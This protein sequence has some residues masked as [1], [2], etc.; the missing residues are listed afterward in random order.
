MAQL[1]QGEDGLWSDHTAALLSVDRLAGV[2]QALHLADALAGRNGSVDANVFLGAQPGYAHLGFAS[3][4]VASASHSYQLDTAMSFSEGFSDT[5]AG[6]AKPS[7]LPQ[8]DCSN[9][10]STLASQQHRTENSDG[11]G[12]FLCTECGKV[13]RRRCEL[14]YSHIQQ[15]FPPIN[16]C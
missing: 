9:S 12:A 10:P 11:E 15:D 16:E 3:N 4:D 8:G 7:A 1:R 5:Q 14:R 6:A 13:K 2:G